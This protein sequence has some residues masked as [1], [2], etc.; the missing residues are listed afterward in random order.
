MDKDVETA[1]VKSFF[2]KRVQD[3]VLFEL[4]SPDKRQ[5]RGL[6]RLCHDY[7]S[8]LREDICMKY[9]HLIPR[10]P[11]PGNTTTFLSHGMFAQ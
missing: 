9:R 7:R 1:I 11:A 8:T 5:N 2:S 6:N 4:F 3:R 10:R